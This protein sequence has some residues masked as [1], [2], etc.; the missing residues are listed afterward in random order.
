MGDKFFSSNRY[1]LN[2]AYLSEILNFNIS[3]RQ[4]SSRS[5]QN[6]AILIF[7]HVKIFIHLIIF[8]LD[9]EEPFQPNRR[10]CINLTNRSDR[11]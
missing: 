3:E 7:F 10:P 1:T 11:I 9:S 5:Y 2:V 6:S 4:A 8:Y